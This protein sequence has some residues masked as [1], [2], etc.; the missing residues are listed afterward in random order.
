MRSEGL[1]WIEGTYMLQ[2]CDFCHECR[3]IKSYGCRDFEY[4]G[5]RVLNGR[6]LSLLSA[7]RRCAHLIDEEEWPELTDRVFDEFLRRNGVRRLDG[8]AVR[9]RIEEIHRMYREHLIFAG[10]TL[11]GGS[12][13]IF[14]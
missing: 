2:E 3:G 4:E 7:C 10:H 11:G 5:N 13:L 14:S 8:L 1:R 9:M 12:S 6:N